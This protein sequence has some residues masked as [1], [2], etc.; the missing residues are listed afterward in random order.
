MLLR[1]R[2]W[3]GGWS[4]GNDVSAL[5]LAIGHSFPG[6]SHR[7]Q[8]QARARAAIVNEAARILEEGIAASR[9]DIDLVLINGYGYP[10]R[11][12]GPI[13]SADRMGLSRCLHLGRSLF[14]WGEGWVE[15]GLL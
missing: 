1:R 3:G 8:I 12:G 9:S 15:G 4:R 5:G 11:R 13:F 14:L 10:A 6:A 7:P 2:Q